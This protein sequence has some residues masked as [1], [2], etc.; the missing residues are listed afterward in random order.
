MHNKEFDLINILI[1][2]IF[3][4]L[5]FESQTMTQRKLLDFQKLHNW[6]EIQ[7]EAMPSDTRIS[8]IDTTGKI[9]DN[10]FFHNGVLYKEI[11]IHSNFKPRSTE[12]TYNV[13]KEMPV[14]WRYS[15]DNIVKILFNEECKE[16]S[17]EEYLKKNVLF[18]FID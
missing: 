3:E 10:C 12:K 4:N 8:V 11:I 5:P 13:V 14:K 15:E 18:N 9:R 1:N 16:N 7:K 6:N 17:V 2:S